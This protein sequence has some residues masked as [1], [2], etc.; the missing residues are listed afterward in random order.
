MCPWS[1]VEA[2][3]KIRKL[4]EKHKTTFFSLSEN[5]CLPAQSTLKP[6]ER[7]FVVDSR[8][9]MHM[10]SRKDLNFAEL[11]TLTTSRSL[12]TVFTAYV[13]VQTNEEATGYVNRIGYILDRESPR[14]YASSL[15]LRKLCDEHGYS[16][17]WI[18]GQKPHLIK[19]GIRIQCNT[20]NC[21]P[22]V[23]PGLSTS[24]SSSLPTSTSLTPSRQEI[25]HSKSSSSSPTSTPMT[26]SMEID[27]SGHLHK[28]CQVNVWKGKNVTILNGATR[29]VLRSQSGCKNSGKIWWMMKFQCTEILTPVPCSKE[30]IKL[31]SDAIERHHPLQYAPSLFYPDGYHDVNWRNHRRESICVTPTASEDFF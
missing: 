19:N 23:V 1:S 16:N 26:S 2:G 17:E 12:T 29:C 31:L 30:R 8:A 6:E 3:Q 28:R 11:E 24:S 20:E 25:D 4:K 5:W 27:Y 21:I 14:G 9:S 18:N 15:S 10:I 13:G 7:K 22:I